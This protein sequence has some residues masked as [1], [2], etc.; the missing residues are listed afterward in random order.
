MAI[1]TLGAIIFDFARNS[2]ILYSGMIMIIFGFVVSLIVTW[3]N[4]KHMGIML[5]P[6]SIIPLIIGFKP[7]IVILILFGIIFIYSA[8]QEDDFNIKSMGLGESPIFNNR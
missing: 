1:E 3:R 2:T 8:W 6:A 4:I 7:N 5:F